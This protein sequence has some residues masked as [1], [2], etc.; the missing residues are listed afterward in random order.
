[1]SRALM[2]LVSLLSLSV[3]LLAQADRGTITGLVTDPSG[4]S[5]PGATITLKNT[6]TN[7]EIA[8]ASG[9][10]GNYSLPN[11][12]VGVYTMTVGAA[13]FR[14]HARSEVQVTVNQTIRLDIVME[15][16]EVTQTVNVTGEIPLIST[17]STDV[18]TTINSKQFQIGR[19]HV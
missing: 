9:S 10:S 11:L 15:V 18:G 1:M 2:Y 19:A 16:G 7:L 17:E 14:T 6:G 3:S 8:T 4:A 13:G 12:P 5:V